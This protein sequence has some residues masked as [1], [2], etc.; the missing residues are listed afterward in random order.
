M[1]AAWLALG[2]GISAAL[3]AEIA[4]AEDPIPFYIPDLDARL[5]PWCPKRCIEAVPFIA[6]YRHGLRKLTFVAVH[7]AFDPSAPTMKAVRTA[8]SSSAAAIVILEGFPTAMGENPAPLVKAAQ[9]YGTADADQ[10]SRSEGMYAASLALARGI[11]FIGGEPSRTEEREGVIRSGFTDADFAFA[12][13][14]GTLGQSLRSGD[15]K[16]GDVTGAEANYSTAAQWLKDQYAITP[17]SWLQFQAQ[18]REM[19]GVDWLNDADATRRDEP[20]V[21]SPVA[22]LKQAQMHVRDEHLLRLIRDRLGS[23]ESVLVVFGGSHWSTLSAALE[24]A[25][26]RPEIEVFPSERAAS[27]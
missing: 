23:G 27:H 5:Q 14:V 11:P 3:Y 10:F 16:A 20:G 12:Y 21:A 17:P 25:Q 15:L 1:K 8:F 19:F 6:R 7:H 18:Y 2:L 9:R 22:R 4:A 26:G 13:L 24:R